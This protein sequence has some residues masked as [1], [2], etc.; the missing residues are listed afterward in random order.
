MRGPRIIR[1]VIPIPGIV[2]DQIKKNAATTDTMV[3]PVYTDDKKMF[4]KINKKITKP[5]EG[6]VDS[7]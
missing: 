6:I 4:S 7:E 5:E 2:T 1:N 3:R